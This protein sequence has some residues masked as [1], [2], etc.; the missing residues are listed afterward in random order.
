MIYETI[1]DIE[2]SSGHTPFFVAIMKGH[3]E[4]AEL[5]LVDKMSNVNHM[6]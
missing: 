4:M 2:D 1:L 5:L 6:D 3:L